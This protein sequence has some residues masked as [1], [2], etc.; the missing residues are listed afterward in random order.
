[1]STVAGMAVVLATARATVMS[2]GPEV[3]ACNVKLDSAAKTAPMCAQKKH[4][5]AMGI[6][7]RTGIAIATIHSPVIFAENALP[8]T[9]VPSAPRD[10]MHENTAI[11][12]GDA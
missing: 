6:V 11:R 8:E 9:L 10:A 4:V 2:D 3:P 1:M 5:M 7:A 12:S